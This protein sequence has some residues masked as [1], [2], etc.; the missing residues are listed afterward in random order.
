MVN[1][2]PNLLL[3]LIGCLFILLFGGLS[4]IRR[5][6]LSAQFAL[7]AAVLTA[8]LVGGSWLTRIQLSP[9]LF[10]ILL[11]LVTMRSRLT[12][13]VAN[14]LAERDKYDLAFRLYR[15]GLAW[16]PDASS[17]L[18]V[19]TNRGVAELRSGQVEEAIATLR[20]VLEVEE[21]PHLG[22]KYEAACQYSLGL[23]YEKR[24][25]SAKAVQQYNE[26]IDTLPGSTYA[27]AAQ[28]ALKRRKK[29][30]SED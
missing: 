25:E 11:Y 6:G 17:R 10:L 18:I 8:L 27:Q 26:A 30:Q 20:S 19:L 12:V 28:A 7:E 4:F 16:W 21:R 24:G 9:F 23:A 1:L 29:E 14:V 5:E 3:L 22:L 2:D 15:L 13:D